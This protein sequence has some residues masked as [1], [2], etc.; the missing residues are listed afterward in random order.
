MNAERKLQ[1]RVGFFVEETIHNTYVRE[2]KPP[3]PSRLV[4]D[5][6]NLLLFLT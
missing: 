6:V 2:I 3:V 5:K 1:G 4:V